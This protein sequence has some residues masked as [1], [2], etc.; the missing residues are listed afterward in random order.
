MNSNET[1]PEPVETVGSETGSLTSASFLGLVLTQ[2]LGA[3]NDNCFRWLGVA[4]ASQ[5]MPAPKAI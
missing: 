2:F 5:V 1:N 3:F 4:I